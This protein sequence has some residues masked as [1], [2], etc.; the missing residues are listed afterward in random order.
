VKALMRAIAGLIVWAVAFCVV[1]GL[2][3]MA[4]GLGWPPGTMRTVL[5]ASWLAF[6]AGGVALLPWLR[7]RDEGLAER[8]A[9]PMGI[10]GVVSTLWTLFP[11]AFSA[12]CV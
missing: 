9:L 2:E 5:V 12:Q 8:L 1:Y 6:V 4:C 3:G 11:V 7:A 10:V